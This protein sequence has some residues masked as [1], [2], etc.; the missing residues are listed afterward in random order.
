MDDHPII[1]QYTALKDTTDPAVRHIVVEAWVVHDQYFGSTLESRIA[2]YYV[3]PEQICSAYASQVTKHLKDKLMA[4][5]ELV[6]AV[7][8]NC[9]LLLQCLN[10]F[11]P[12]LPSNDTY[13]EL[14]LQV[15]N[16]VIYDLRSFYD[17]MTMYHMND[18][19]DLGW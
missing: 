3:S 11:V 1:K 2:D 9:T 7:A 18:I 8:N 19:L 13:Q 4:N 17:Y 12:Q 6:M 5:P 16:G 15:N 10:D 14:V